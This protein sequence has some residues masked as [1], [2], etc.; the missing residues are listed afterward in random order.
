MNE[1]VGEYVPINGGFSTVKNN[2]LILETIRKLLSL[3]VLM[4]V[5]R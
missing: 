4:I 5:A 1:L 3:L 2:F